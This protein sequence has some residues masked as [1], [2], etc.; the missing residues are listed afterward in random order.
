[1]SARQPS[2]QQT[3]PPRRIGEILVASGQCAQASVFDALALQKRFGGQLGDILVGMGAVTGHSVASALSEQH[4]IP[5]VSLIAGPSH[6]DQDHDVELLHLMPERFWWDNLIVPLSI[7]DDGPLV[8]AAVDPKNRA[9]IEQLHSSLRR[10]IEV[11]VTAYRDVRSALLRRYSEMISHRSRA[12]LSLERPHDSAH[13]MALKRQSLGVVLGVLAAI[14][15]LILAPTETL[16]A[17]NTVVE[18]SYL[19]LFG[20]KF[21]LILW[22]FSSRGCQS[23]SEPPALNPVDLPMYTILVPAYREAAI[24][25]T[26]ARA[27]TELDYP[28]DRLDVKLLLEEDDVDT[29]R[30]A[31]ALNLPAFIDIV[32]VPAAEPR[33]KPKACNYG[34]EMARGEFVVIFDAEDIP[35]PGQLRR[36]AAVLA[37]APA[38]V[39]CVQAKLAIYNRRTNFLT[40]WFAAEYM[41]WFDLLLP[42]LRAADLPIPLG[43]T[44]NHFRVSALR[45]VGAW[46]PHN[47]TEDADLGIR[48]HRAGYRT[49]VIDSSTY[50]EAPTSL[51]VWIRQRS[52]WV[53]GYMQT[54]LVHMRHPVSLWNDLDP[55]GFFAFQALIGGTPATFLLTPI[56]AL[57]T[58]M[59]AFTQYAGISAVFPGWV[60]DMAMLNILAGTFVFSYIQM[61]APARRGAWDTVRAA[62]F[63]PV[64]WFMMSYASWRALYQLLTRPSFWEK[65]PHGA[66]IAPAGDD[67]AAATVNEVAVQ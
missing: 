60:Y 63:S 52:R 66:H 41:A 17:I 62:A 40:H 27:L 33:T 32:L 51:L 53:K 3:A 9:A 1:M 61:I 57:L 15:A 54:W 48:L 8:V 31:L 28:R 67:T 36:T 38:D 65:T 16:V 39:A 4:N 6:P 19:G 21:G 59:W 44:S 35:D 29:R 11:H 26:L 14:V 30:A 5:H 56:Y 10:P 43:G 22:R 47:V 34:L 64:Y 12:L 46:D 50:E 20:G 49:R 58:T 18:V 24:L 55:K 25:P 13:R 42:A 45:E 2:D 7:S 37:T 23:E